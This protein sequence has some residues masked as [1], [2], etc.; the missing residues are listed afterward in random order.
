MKALVVYYS[1]TGKTEL[2]AKAI[3]R[4]L[5]ADVRKVEEVQKRKGVVGLISGGHG[6]RKGE[7]GEIKPMDFNLDKYDLIFLGTPVWALKPTP[8]INAFISKANFKDK[9][10]VIFVTMGGFGGEGV[11]RELVDAIESKGGKI[12]NLFVVRTGG[13]KKEKITEK[14]NEIG[15]LYK[16]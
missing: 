10:L 7:C 13:V 2:V 4:T 12:I 8:A 11:I 3:A 16:S 5:S 6:A 9:K 14:G 15:R 1:W